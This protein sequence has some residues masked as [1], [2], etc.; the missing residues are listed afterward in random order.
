VSSKQGKGRATSVAFLETLWLAVDALRA[1]KLRSFLTLLG[2]ILAVFTLVLVISTV[3]GMNGYVAE[4]VANLGAG[5]FAV[6]RLGVI[7]SF[8]E[9]I[10]AR[11]RP[12]IKLEHYELL[13]DN[14]TL[15]RRVAG[16]AFTRQDVRYGN[17]LIEDVR[18]VGASPDYA[19]MRSFTVGYGRYMNETDD[20]HR[21][22]VC[23][24]GPDLVTKFFPT[25]DP[26]GKS[27]RVGSQVYEII[28]VGKPIGSV[29]GQ[30]QDNYVQL[31][32][33]TFLKSYFRPD[34][35]LLVFVQ[36]RN[37]ELIDAAQDEARM[38]MRA[39]RHL[40]YNDPD[41]F[42]FVGSS[43]ITGLWEEISG[44]IF[45]IAVG[46]TS[47]FMV[48][49]GI[50]IMNIML[51]SVTE[52]T[53]EIGIRKSLGARRRHIVM[54]FLVESSIMAATGGAVGIFVAAGLGMLVTAT[55]GFPIV[56]PLWAVL[57][58]LTMSTSVGLFF[59]IYP[60]VRASRLDPIEALRAEV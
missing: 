4:K 59:G 20:E 15:A 47:V 22:P 23:F 12:P 29:L 34:D 19:E 39:R 25:V 43:T 13:R 35:S 18:I 37:A 46:L 3:E 52:R 1:H 55:S 48:V 31:P 44:N 60:A 9:F 50:V 26:L 58:A 42:A 11:K 57:L 38:I 40:Q 10:K 7:T 5:V 53:R 28:G 14:M 8:E 33:G 49:G 54:Q 45:R 21:S 27:I 41:N 6:D 32:L 24:V 36:A 56:T 2:V 30:S 51:A 16:V 17:D